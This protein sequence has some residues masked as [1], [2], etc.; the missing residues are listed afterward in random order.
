MTG[1]F[2]LHRIAVL[3]ERRTYRNFASEMQAL[4][5]RR[6]SC[7]VSVT[8]QTR[9]IVKYLHCACFYLR[10][11]QARAVLSNVLM[12]SGTIQ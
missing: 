2:R 6:L 4:F 9:A 5:L 3:A 8:F 12:Y 7:S 10:N 1:S 11:E